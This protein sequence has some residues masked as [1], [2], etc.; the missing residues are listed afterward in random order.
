MATLIGHAGLFVFPAV[1]N[2]LRFYKVFPFDGSRVKAVDRE[3]DKIR[4][5][6][7]QREDDI[8]RVEFKNTYLKHRLKHAG[9]P[10]AEI[11]NILWI[12]SEWKK[13]D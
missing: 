2:N 1:I 11:E 3:I 8:Y 7:A 4:I 6:L 13:D 10:M 12:I 9:Q 5:K